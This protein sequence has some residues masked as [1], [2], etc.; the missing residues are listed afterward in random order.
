MIHI[1][2]SSGVLAIRSRDSSSPSVPWIIEKEQSS[3]NMLEI[4]EVRKSSVFLPD[5]TSLMVF[6]SIVALLASFFDGCHRMQ[7]LSARERERERERE[8]HEE[9]FLLCLITF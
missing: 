8:V 3:R 9:G 2:A 6:S 1:L 4:S 7:L 5:L